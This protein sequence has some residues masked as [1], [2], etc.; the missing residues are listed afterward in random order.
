[1]YDVSVENGILLRNFFIYYYVSDDTDDVGIALRT[2]QSICVPSIGG[3]LDYN[4][5]IG[6]DIDK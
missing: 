5:E 3:I 6:H 1:M 2:S 4:L